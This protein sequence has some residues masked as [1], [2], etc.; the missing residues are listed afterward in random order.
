MSVSLD[1]VNL[2]DMKYLLTGLHINVIRCAELLDK[3]LIGFNELTGIPDKIVDWNRAGGNSQGALSFPERGRFI[4]TVTQMFS[5]SKGMFW[6]AGLL[7]KSGEKEKA[8]AVFINMHS[9]SLDI[10]MRLEIPMRALIKGGPPLKGTYTVYLHSLITEQ[11]GDFVYYGITKRNWNVR[12]GEHTK[13]AVKEQ[14]GRSFA[15]RMNQ[16]I[17]ARVAE[18]T[19]RTE[20][21]PRLTGIV[22]VLCAVGLTEKSALDTEEYL[23]DKYSL[24]SKHPNGLNMIPGGRAG[25]N[26]LSKLSAGKAKI[27]PETQE[28]ERILDLYDKPDST[29]LKPE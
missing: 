22:S 21:E 16:L 5:P 29:I 26:T 20:N 1:Y 27:T 25:F 4:A 9:P 8:P 10:P 17:G 18:I 6:T 14:S 19:G 11:A 2:P 23:V 28:R 13:A 3:T 15:K 7:E 24:S 12:F